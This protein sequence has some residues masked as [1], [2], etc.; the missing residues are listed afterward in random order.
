MNQE[1]ARFI[2]YFNHIPKT[3]GTSLR[4]WLNSLFLDSEIYPHLHHQPDHPVPLVKSG[5]QLIT[6][7]H[8]CNVHEDGLGGFHEVT[9]IREPRAWVRSYYKFVRTFDYGSLP[10][11]VPIDKSVYQIKKMSYPEFLEEFGRPGGNLSGFQSRYLYTCSPIQPETEPY[12]TVRRKSENRLKEFAIVGSLGHMQE[13]VDLFCHRF[14]LPPKRFLL[15]ENRSQSVLEIDSTRE[16]LF[17]S[18][19]ADVDLYK[20]VS[21]NVL[22]D[23]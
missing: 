7:H 12:E 11:G 15:W 6:G 21:E 3:G 1:P 16:E 17:L 14:K 19:N 22:K 18:R 13:S 2:L 20:T 10:P 8:A 4:S 23:F 5:L 9:W